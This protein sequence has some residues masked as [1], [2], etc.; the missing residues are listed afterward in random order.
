MSEIG[1][2]R[3]HINKAIT[4]NTQAAHIGSLGLAKVR[5]LHKSYTNGYDHLQ[6]IMELYGPEMASV[7]NVHY[8][9]DTD[10]LAEFFSSAKGHA[11][12]SLDLLDGVLGESK[13]G[14][15]IIGGLIRIRM[16][17]E[18]LEVGSYRLGLYQES[19]TN[20]LEIM[21]NLPEMISLSGGMVAD[22]VN[23]EEYHSKV[24][25]SALDYVLDI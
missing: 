18:N 15:D 23:L 19:S 5:T 6:K 20:I 3:E 16:E 2:A 7:K 25:S 24:N 11:K 4:E 21:T 10:E 8:N 13:K 1:R 17:Y 12:N 22:C 14:S 9:Y